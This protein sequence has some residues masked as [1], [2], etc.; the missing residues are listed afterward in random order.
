MCCC[1][2]SD[3]IQLTVAADVARRLRRCMPLHASA[4]KSSLA[5]N[6]GTND[7]RLSVIE[8]TANSDCPSLS[9][10]TPPPGRRYDASVFQHL[11]L[12]ISVT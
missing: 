12:N 7:I 6:W 3:E 5:G 8:A 1:V 4:S 2:C 11:N 10:V 9:K